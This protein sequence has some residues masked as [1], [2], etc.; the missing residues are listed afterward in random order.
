MKVC[1]LYA[2][3]TIEA[4]RAWFME[5]E[6]FDPKKSKA[7]TSAV[8]AL[9]GELRPGLGSWPRASACRRAG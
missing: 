1:D 7:I 4:N 2:L 8:D 6:A 3:A 9:C 5:H